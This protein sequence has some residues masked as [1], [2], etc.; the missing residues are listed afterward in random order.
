MRFLDIGPLLPPAAL[1]CDE[2]MLDWAE[3]DVDEEL[4][5]IYEPEQPF[6][7]LGL[8]NEVEKEVHVAACRARAIPLLRRCSGGGTVLQAPGCLN[9]SLVLRVRP[10]AGLRDLHDTHARVLK[11]HQRVLENLLQ[12]KVDIQGTSDLTLGALKF[13]G[14]A[15]R[16]KQR[17]VL[18]HGTF[19]L[20]AD[21]SLIEAVLRM[22]SR[23]PD[24][25]A[26]RAHHEFLTVLPLQRAPLESALR[27]AW[28]A[29]ALANPFPF[30][31]VHD[32]V[33][34]KYGT[35]AWNLRR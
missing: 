10:E 24:Y 5:R 14:N 27:T 1:A 21:L 3:Q 15:Q 12:R 25:R 9:F 11:R 32:L 20:K 29:Q 7:V 33:R 2:V 35:D 22:P 13:S 4:L 6:V 18:Y 16:R 31:R 8:G 28:N 19:L 23:E 17:F 34:A 26:H 30:E